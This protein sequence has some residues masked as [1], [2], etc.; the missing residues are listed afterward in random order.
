MPS[1]RSVLRAWKDLVARDDDR[2]LL[3][4]TLLIAAGY[5]IGISITTEPGGAI[6]EGDAK[7]YFSYLPSLVLDRDVNLNDEFKQ[8][9][10]EGV[11]SYPYG[12]GPAGRAANPFPIAPALLWLPGYLLGLGADYLLGRLGMAGQPFGYGAGA[13]WGAAVASILWA[14]VG[15]V[16]TR[17]VIASCLGEGNALAAV[18]MTWLGTAAIY[19]TLVAPLYS[20][21]VSW[22]GV[23]A[24][25]SLSH[26]AAT[27]PLRPSRWLGA[28]LVAGYLVA[29]RLPHGALLVMPAFMLA[30]AARDSWPQWRVPTVCLLAWTVGIG[31]GYLPQ[32]VASFQ[33]Y[34][35][36]FVASPG[37]L[38]S[39]FEASV[40]RNALFS[41]GYEG[42][43]S[44]SPIVLAGLVGV[45]LLAARGDS[46]EARRL[47]CVAIL[48]LVSIYLTDVL[49]PYG[50]AG[51]AF[52]ARRY[53]SAT[54]LLA[55]GL[56]ALLHASAARPWRRLVAVLL[57][58]LTIWNVCLLVSYELLVHRQGIYPTLLQT[59]RH[60][61]GLGVR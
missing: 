50:R 43:I 21:A 27:H 2:L 19:Y 8:L 15:A 58:G 49:H 20:H 33:L 48:G 52:G 55:L 29:I 59:I 10:P 46:T 39:G 54:P 25:L 42:W 7:G 56:G 28:G 37:Q 4:F 44:W 51:A 35:R 6:V 12:E 9:E 40:L 23:A 32:G 45:V 30:V 26:R 57:G 16:V 1:L 17:R 53:V 47:G 24:M 41:I 13:V 61:L 11:A 5:M 31:L 36:W 60:A 34:G 3:T 18:A 14:G 38:G 22:F